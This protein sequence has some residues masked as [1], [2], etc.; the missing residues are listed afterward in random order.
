LGRLDIRLAGILNE[1]G[2]FFRF[3]QEIV[4]YGKT[5]GEGRTHVNGNLFNALEHAVAKAGAV[6]LPFSPDE[7]VENLRY[8]RYVTA[9][10]S[11]RLT[12]QS[13]IRA[14]YYWL[15]PMFPVSVRRYLQRIYL[16]D[17]D[18]ISFPNWPVDRSVDKVLEKILLFCMKALDMDR[19]PFIWFWPDGQRACAIMT[20]DVETT[21][22]H[23]FSGKLMDLDDSFGLKSSFQIVPEKRYEVSSD[24]VHSIRTRGFEVNV[25]GLDHDGNLFEDRAEFVEA[26]RKINDYALKFGARG[27][28]SPVLYR[29]A[30]WFQ[31]L[32]F[33]YDMSFP[34]VGRLEAQRGGC[35]TVMPY[36]L[37]GGMLE[38]P[39]TMIE[40][41]TL[42]H[43]LGDYSTDLWKQ[44]INLILEGHG[45]VSAV[46]HPDYVGE[47][48]AQSVYRQ[49][50]EELA[51]L[52]SDKRVWIAVPGDVDRWWRQ[53]AAMQ[54]IADDQGLRIEGTGSD[55]A[56]IAYACIDG[57][58]LAYEI[59]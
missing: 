10:D 2:G 25:H 36:F 35:C 24:Y 15:R 28:R 52:R 9:S 18:A 26:A 41:Y 8:E 43:I 34:N 51:S 33:S 27:F 21:A 54:L 44:Q 32:N 16:R 58:R 40:D 48:R 5:L 14:M 39:L 7:V 37:P 19:L 3:G 57:D 49:L 11:T 30:N 1:P 4:C 13:W 38:L 23:D 46:V 53:R 31:D 50:L 20:H 55:R 56:R 29:N 42:F 47:V 22:G 45:L 17:W 59:S 12:Q 6:S